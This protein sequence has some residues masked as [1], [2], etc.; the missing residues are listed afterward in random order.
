MKTNQVQLLG[1]ILVLLV[2]AVCSLAD[3]KESLSTGLDPKVDGTTNG[4]KEE[5]GSNFKS[6][7]IEGD[8]GKE[9]G[10]QVDKS[11]VNIADDLNKNKMD[12]QSESKDSDNVKKGK[13]NSSEEFQAK[14]G[15]HDKKE[16]SSGGVESNDLP[17]E[18]NG[19]GDTQSRKEGPRVEECDPSNM[20]MDE[21]NKLVACLRVPGNESP[22]LSLLI[23]NKGKV[24]LSVT[25]SAPDFVQLEKT[26]IQLQEKEDK[27]VKV[28][29]TSGGS[30]NLI[31]LTAGKG[32]CK[33]DIKDTIAHYFGKEF[34]NPHKSADIINFMSRTSTVAVLSFAALL[35]LASG[36]MC[37]IFRRKHLSNSS[38]KYQR[39]EMEL[40]VS[41]GGSQS[42][43]LMMDGIIVG[44]M[45][46]TMKRHLSCPHY[47]SLQAFRPKALLHDG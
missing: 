22:D 15:D 46:G 9:K 31:V 3:S 6:N 45:I 4:S 44:V 40:P 32:Q 12:G 38:S 30:E 7:S 42:P 17:K 43:K 27:K 37:I 2:V 25:I 20:C 34:D 39:L 24:P 36:W 23:Q 13:D 11:K 10:G 47:P 19:K 5:R 14:E 28:S 1:L 18:K 8:K 33:L 26:K 16:D 35:I 21:E 29:I 41:G